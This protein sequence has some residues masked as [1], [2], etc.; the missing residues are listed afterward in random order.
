VKI[1]KKNS[2]EGLELKTL[3]QIINF[4]FYLNHNELKYHYVYIES[5]SL[6]LSYGTVRVL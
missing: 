6:E 3:N 5:D 4:M 2:K 1:Y